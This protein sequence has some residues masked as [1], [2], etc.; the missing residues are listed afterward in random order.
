MRAQDDDDKALEEPLLAGCKDPEES[1]PLGS[2]LCDQLLCR[3]RGD[4]AQPDRLRRMSDR[5]GT[6]Q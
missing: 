3:P 4:G 5:H 6:L 2:R 1:V